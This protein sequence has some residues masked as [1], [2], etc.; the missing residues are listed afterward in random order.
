MFFEVLMDSDK[1]D[2]DMQ[3]LQSGCGLQGFVFNPNTDPAEKILFLEQI[4]LFNIKRKCIR[5]EMA[6]VQFQMNKLL[7][8]ILPELAP[9]HAAL[10]RELIR[11]APS[12]NGN[13]NG[14]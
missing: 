14:G 6:I 3:A 8:D 2:P 5:A 11:P 4:A 13:R 10:V 1:F 9:E 7:I 12:R